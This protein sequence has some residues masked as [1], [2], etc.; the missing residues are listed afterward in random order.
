MLD[1]MMLELEGRKPCIESAPAINRPTDAR[2][3]ADAR[4][5]RARF[6]TCIGTHRSSLLASLRP[7]DEQHGPSKRRRTC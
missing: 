2:D 5:S 4:T 6:A 1:Q 7:D 3:H